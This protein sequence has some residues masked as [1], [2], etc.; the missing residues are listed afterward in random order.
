MRKRLGL[1]LVLAGVLAACGGGGGSGD[2]GGG[3]GGGGLPQVDPAETLSVMEQSFALFY[4]A[5]YPTALVGVPVPL[6]PPYALLPY[7]WDCAG[8]TVTGNP[9][10]FDGDGVPVNA[11]YNGGCSVTG[12]GNGVT[13]TLSWNFKDVTVQDPDDRDP[14][15]GVKANGEV[16]WVLT[17]NDKSYTLTWTI[18]KYEFLHENTR[19]TFDYEGRWVL[20][21][22]GETGT[23]N[24]AF[25]GS[26]TPDDSDDPFAA[27]TLNGNVHYDVTDPDC[28]RGW[29]VDG[30]LTGVHSTEEK[31]DGGT[32]EITLTDCDG[33]QES[34]TVTWSESQICVQ[35]QGEAGPPICAPNGSE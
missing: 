14:G 18:T 6:I 1:A 35:V 31:I 9:T 19:F 17:V 30:T 24:Y 33:E 3:G 29:Q 23:V 2:S 4:R 34:M 32:A 16:Q 28:A 26:W 12:T 11:T 13:V 10:D 7:G 20:S 8:V 15:A 5:A 27:G 25:D 22:D 21:A